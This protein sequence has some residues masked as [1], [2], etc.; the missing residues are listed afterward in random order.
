MGSAQAEKPPLLPL[1]AQAAHKSHDHCVSD[2]PGP[3]PT[4]PR[5]MLLL[6]V[7]LACVCFGSVASWPAVLL[8]R[9]KAQSRNPAYLIRASHG[10]VASEQRMCSDIGV[11][12]MKLGGNA[13]DS[14]I[15]TTFCIGVV[16]CFS[17]VIP[18]F[19]STAP[20]LTRYR[21]QVWHRRRRVHDSASSKGQWFR[22]RHYRL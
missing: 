12:M 17:Y 7:M 8:P 10:A 9:T 18:R 11:D 1:P 22:G 13:V 19:I 16:N 21:P 20:Q 5:A 14:A 2:S 3:V 4:R 15:A 6:Y